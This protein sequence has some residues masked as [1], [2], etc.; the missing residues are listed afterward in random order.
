MAM[1]QYQDMFVNDMQVYITVS[2]ET[3]LRPRPACCQH[4]L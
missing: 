1:S 3:S 4:E 2:G